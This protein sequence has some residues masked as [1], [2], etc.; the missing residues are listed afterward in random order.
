MGATLRAVR[1]LRAPLLMNL[2]KQ[3]KTLE[4]SEMLSCLPLISLSSSISL[5]VS[6]SLKKNNN[7]RLAF[8]PISRYTN[9]V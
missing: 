5:T 1:A 9:G 8:L 6:L 7:C 4:F 3:M 2:Q